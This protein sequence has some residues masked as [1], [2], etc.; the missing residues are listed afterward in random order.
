MKTLI[1]GL[2][3]TFHEPNTRIYRIV[4]G[5][6]WALIILSISLL[7]VEAVVPDGSTADPLLRRF[8][9]GIL[10]IF[11]VEI[12]LRIGTFRPPALK[13]FRRP[14]FGRLRAHVLA[15]L[16]YALR[17][18]MLIDILAVLALFPELRGLR[19]LR[20]L[21]LLR[22]SRVFRY[23]N[24]FAIVIQALEENGLLFAFAFSVLGVT[25][26]LGGITIYLVEGRVNPGLQTM[27]DGV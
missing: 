1:D 18:M 20:L 11:A 27:A 25:T 7:V 16:G 2:Y 9:R 17:P 14:P 12:V 6:V 26:L 5:T 10:I 19:V 21:R 24:P 23:R 13:V 3:A 8:D 22:T 15:R 4:Q